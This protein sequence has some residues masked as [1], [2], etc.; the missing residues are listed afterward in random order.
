MFCN[1]AQLPPEKQELA[2]EKV[3]EDLVEAVVTRGLRFNDCANG[4]NLQFKIDRAWERVS[5]LD[6]DTEEQ[7]DWVRHLV[8]TECEV[9]LKAIAV[10]TAR[11]A[12][13]ISNETVINLDQL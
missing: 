5:K 12:T 13:Y 2:Q 3:F 4:S 10:Q 11:D 8:A 6:V 7:P 9:E 1:Y